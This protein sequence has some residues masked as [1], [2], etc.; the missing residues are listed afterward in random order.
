[1]SFLVLNWL[2]YMLCKLCYIYVISSTLNHYRS[3]IW[4]E[5]VTRFVLSEVKWSESHSI[6]SDTLQPHDYTVHGILQARMLEWVAFPFSRGSSQ[7]RDQTLSCI[8]GG[9]F[10]SWATREAQEY[11][12]GQPVLYPADLPDPGIK[13]GSPAVQADSLPAELPMNPVL[14]E[15]WCN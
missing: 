11:W 3:C 9:F 5:Q 10:T 15:E 7:P 13:P 12:C 8:T 4:Q 14:S 6:G 1:M 2:T